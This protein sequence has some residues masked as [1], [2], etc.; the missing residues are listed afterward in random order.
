MCCTPR[1][2]GGATSSVSLSRRRDPPPT[3]ATNSACGVPSAGSSSAVLL[4]PRR[5]AAARAAPSAA[6]TA[7][8]YPAGP[9][10]A[11]LP[12]VRGGARSTD[13][14]GRARACDE[15]GAGS[16]RGVRGRLGT[17]AS[18]A[19]EAR[20]AGA[21]P[22]R[23]RRSR[24]APCQSSEVGTVRSG[25]RPKWEPSKVGTSEVGTGPTHRR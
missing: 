16:R 1:V 20:A 9:M 21:G 11:C 14:R 22:C 19:A 23:R 2:R 13:A 7:T 12:C 8:G 24:S 4:A 5:A 17:C 6:G 25:S 10:R 18:S 15:G 3:T